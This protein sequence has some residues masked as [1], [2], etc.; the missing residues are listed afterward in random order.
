MSAPPIASST[1]ESV[2]KSKVSVPVVAN[3]ALPPPVE[4]LPLP[5]LPA[6]AGAWA[7]GAGTVKAL[8]LELAGGA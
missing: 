7:S 1:M 3:G 8:S 5:E 4:V 6:A 2:E